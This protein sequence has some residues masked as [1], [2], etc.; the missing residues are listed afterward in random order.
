MYAL[1][2]TKRRTAALISSKVITPLH[3][4]PHYIVSGSFNF[5]PPL[6]IAD[7]ASSTLLRILQLLLFGKSIT[8]LYIH[9]NAT[10]W[11]LAKCLNLLND[12]N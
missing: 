8:L 3:G 9:A 10:E 7:A 2:G 4:S 11:L 12:E 5:L 1:H 6:W